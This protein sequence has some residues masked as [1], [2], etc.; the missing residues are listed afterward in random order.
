MAD[1]SYTVDVKGHEDLPKLAAGITAVATALGNGKDIATKLAEFKAAM[2]GMGGSLD[3]IKGLDKKI[4]NLKASING[5]ADNFKREMLNTRST[6]AT[7][8][9]GISAEFQKIG[10]AA[11]AG[12]DEAGAA[13]KVAADKNL[14][15]NVKYATDIETATR[16]IQEKGTS[17][18]LQSLQTRASN[19]QRILQS[20]AKNAVAIAQKT[21]GTDF[22]A[23]MQG[24]LNKQLSVLTNSHQATIRLQRAQHEQMIAEGR[25]AAAELANIQAQAQVK[26]ATLNPMGNYSS[27]RSGREFQI[28][29]AQLFMNMPSKADFEAATAIAVKDARDAQAKAMM[30]VRAATNNPVGA[31]QRYNSSTQ[32]AGALI[33]ANSTNALTG[34]VSAAIPKAQDIGQVKQLSTAFQ[35]LT[36]DGNDVHSAMRGL[37]SG[38]NLLWLTWGNLLP[39]FAGAAISNGFMKTAKEGLK[40]TQT[41]G[42][43]AYLGEN[44]TTEMQALTGELV[45]MGNEGIYGPTAIAEA[46]QTLSLA[47]LKANE[48][49]AV[50]GTV[51]GFSVAGATDI[52]T[53][54]DVLVSVTTAFGTGAAGFSR[55]AD[56]IMR[57]AADSKASVESFGEAMKTASVVGEQYGAKQED[58]ALLIQYLANLGI[59]GSAAGTAVRNMYADISGRSGP[60]R[61]AM[62]E[63]GLDFRDAE[64]H[65][66]G[67]KEQT[68]QLVGVLSKYDGK[69]QANIIQAIYG[70]RGAK[71]AIELLVKAKTYI[72]ENGKLTTQLEID[73]RKLENA[74]G[75]A[76]IA[77]IKMGT[78]TQNAFKAAGAT[79][80][81]TLFG[82]FT[83]MEPQ[84]YAVAVALREAFGS[85]DLQDTLAKLVSGVAD[86]A[87]YVAENI[88]TIVTAGLAYGAYKLA[89]VA[90][91]VAYGAYQNILVALETAKAINLARTTAQAAAELELGAAL[92]I[93]TAA[94]VNAAKAAATG[95]A[96]RVGSLTVMGSLAKAIP[97]VGTAITLAGLAW[98]GYDMWASRSGSTM[99]DLSGQKSKDMITALRKEND[100]LEAV[101]EARER[102]LSLLEAEALVKANNA[103]SDVAMGGIQKMSGIQ[104]EIDI[105]QGQK[106]NITNLYGSNVPG[107]A[108]EQ[109]KALDLQLARKRVE[110]R[111][112]GEE[113]RK[114]QADLAQEEQRR[115]DNA[116]HVSV[117]NVAAREKETAAT[118]KL[119]DEYRKLYGTGS[120]TWEQTQG[121]VNSRTQK[122]R[123]YDDKTLPNLQKQMDS[124]LSVI[125]ARF[126]SEKSIQDSEYKNLLVTKGQYQA[127][128]L[129]STVTYEQESLASIESHAKDY[130]NAYVEQYAEIKKVRDG[131]KPDSEN[132]KAEDA[133]LEAL[134]NKAT[135]DMQADEDKH[136][137][138]KL[139]SVQRQI[140]AANELAGETRKLIKADEEYWTKSKL[141][142]DKIESM[143]KVAEQYR[144]INTSVLSNATALKAEA[145]AIAESKA[146]H[147]GQLQNMRKEIE[148]RMDA[149]AALETQIELE[150]ESAT[151][152]GNNAV[153]QELSK[154]KGLSAE[155]LARLK[156][157]YSK[158]AEEGITDGARRG[159]LAYQKEMEAKAS[160]VTDSIAGA[161]ETAIFKSGKEGGKALRDYL[162]AEL[163]RKPLMAIVK[164]IIQPI[165]SM[166]VGGLMGGG[167]GGGGGAGGILG[168]GMQGVGLYNGLTSGTGM[169]G[170]VGNWLGLGATGGAVGA[171][172]WG[173]AAVAGSYAAPGIGAVGS[174]GG[175][176][177]GGGMGAAM[178]AVAPWL[179]GATAIAALWK[180]LFG[181]TLKDSGI[182]GTFG[183]ESGF[184]GR[185]YK[186]YEGG[187]FR[188]DKTSYSELDEQVRKTLG[189]TFKTMKQQVTDFADVLG[190]ST[191]RLKGYTS[192]MKLSLHGLSE[193]D[194]QKKI[195]EA[196]ATQNNEMAQ[197]V[198]GTWTDVTET[199]KR[200][201]ASTAME[202][203]N[204]AGAYRE[205]EET[206]TRSTYKSSEFA[207]EGE[208]AID[209]LTRLA[210]SLTLANTWFARFGATLFDASL[211]GGDKASSFIDAAGGADAFNQQA[212]SYFN[213]FYTS[214]Q[215]RAAMRSEIEDKLGKAGVAMPQTAAEFRKAMD[216]FL[217][218][219]EAGKDGAA[220]LFGV[221]DAFAEVNGSIGDLEQAMG[222]SAQ[223]IKG[224]L[225]DVRK[226]AATPAE[227]GKRLEDS[228]YEGLGNA[229]TQ[230]LSQMIM[231]AVV[232][233]LVD[234]LLTGA[235]GS[236]AALAAGGV[237]GG[238][239]AA[240]GGAAAGGAVAAGGAAAGSAMA[241]GGAMAG[242]AVAATIDQARAYMAGF[243]A[244]M[245]DPGVRDTIRDIA[246]GFSTIAGDLAGA[247]GGF[248]SASTAMATT[249]S[250]AGSMGDSVTSLGDS[251]EAEVKRLRGLMVDASPMKGRD[252]LLAEFTTATAQARAGDQSALEKLPG[253]S[254]SLEEATRLSAGS[255]VEL[256]RM[257]GWL[258]GSLVETQS[259]F[260]VQTDA[261]WRAA[262]ANMTSPGYDIRDTPTYSSSMDAT[263]TYHPWEEATVDSRYANSWSTTPI[264]GTGRLRGQDPNYTPDYRYANSWDTIPYVANPLPGYAQGTPYVPEDGLAMLHKGEMVIPAA[265]NPAG[266]SASAGGQND[267]VVQELRALRVEVVELR[268]Q[269]KGETLDQ[270]RINLRTAKILERWEQGGM[271]TARQDGV[272]A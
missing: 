88:Q 196:L 172:A 178:A 171:G 29:N 149:I 118:K 146:Q 229:M 165:S 258:A 158:S 239:G 80:E 251:I 49:L 56:I 65:V 243:A 252:A 111:Q 247:T 129:A 167:G 94:E 144:N 261:Q 265:Y 151:Y 53:A 242:A 123:S 84:L 176:S 221:A 147:E 259:K 128:V 240:A 2:G 33:G 226:G 253:L 270:Q 182:E 192:T 153:W 107:Y 168:M 81:T 41:L 262:R 186:F 1:L 105:L 139:D 24:G 31:F 116:I 60:A 263:P 113:S 36:V 267:E 122:P 254:Q 120:Q 58:V 156:A 231:S 100:H 69:S 93:R 101:N 148:L 207:R 230:G 170:T 87:K 48:I 140:L 266:R 54:A 108:Q 225:D 214:N 244:I 26:A 34:S 45:R 22:V 119:M 189:D 91:T 141:E 11:S 55:S 20:E 23:A 92:G 188:S 83:A 73:Q 42:T 235:T 9:A 204:G 90:V 89:V 3:D 64:G 152:T 61:K 181:R 227:A 126:D 169:L 193:G 197:Q 215:R 18:M 12:L 68:D 209:T 37:A 6:I 233:P 27:M 174:L 17:A 155:E 177:A 157:R 264:A 51:M 103:K 222:I 216:A 241:Q 77:A 46:M 28:K 136:V 219:G 163:I 96:A 70:E 166:I 82:A 191:E 117:L 72:L 246:N 135:T 206:I 179:L 71:A 154:T 59:Q 38:F 67:L 106:S 125:K 97:F 76:A 85:K 110:M 145:E 200:Q 7:N 16:Q 211:G 57:A 237:A 272:I 203:E 256:A 224:I 52:K 114:V 250:S 220:A 115:S 217:A 195:Q 212:S 184:E 213:N 40:V 183:G 74:Y 160:A 109:A 202:M 142:T 62:K 102:G 63:L 143:Q 249:T 99:D 86:I 10:K 78:T 173:G 66:I 269:Q 21:Y 44:T 112:A 150:K 190:L 238:T 43:I 98:M 161:I 218:M 175:V 133:K 127:K 95:A 15:L 234:G 255:S 228:I 138:I 137:K 257:R 208:K 131:F 205:V 25:K 248:Q 19:I 164:A 4:D 201:V 199:V 245:N 32:T 260:A 232:G 121:G 194:A 134:R 8:V 268:T 39:L 30:Q 35:K 223:S 187:L 198:I 210:T 104:S 47:G 236:A 159:A 75:D 185:N 124:E 180:P 130:V 162:Q 271:P 13:L 5:L 132:W 79:L 14:K 50:T